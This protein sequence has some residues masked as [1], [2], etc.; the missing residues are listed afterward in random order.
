MEPLEQKLTE[1][2]TEVKSFATK[3]QEEIKN[4]GA[5]TTETKTAMDGMK[6]KLDAL[7]TQL[8]AVDAKTQ[9]Q[10]KIPGSEQKSVAEMILSHADYLEAKTHDFTGHKPVTMHFDSSAFAGMQRKTNITDSTIGFATTGVLMPVRLPG[11]FGIAR[12]ELR[13]RDLMRIR[14]MTEGSSFDFI[15]QSVR[16]NA[17]SPQIEAAPKAESTYLWTTVSDQ[18]RTIAHFTN[19]S[20][21]ALSDIPWMQQTLNSELIYGLKVKEE[22]EVLSGIGS[23]VHLNG[24]ITQST[25]FDTTL[26]TAAAGWQR[27]DVLRWAKLQARLAGLATYA[28]SGFVLHPTDMAHLETTKDAYGRYII[29]DPQTGVEVKTIWNLPV[30]ESDAMTSGTFLVGAFDT[31]AVLIDRQAT[32]VEISYEHASNFTANLATILCEERIGL[33]VGVPTAFISGTFNTSP[34]TQG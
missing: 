12:Y 28:P 21:Q 20:K 22:A 27:I 9:Q 34:A 25:A 26:L 14:T 30:V 23:G 4:L 10:I 17:T 7:Q 6:V 33:A 32:S 31:A 19:V 16:T 8:D 1:L 29:G 24:I 18:I 15:R 3:A 5:V 11:V 13:V 2:S